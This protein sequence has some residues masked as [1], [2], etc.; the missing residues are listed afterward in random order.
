MGIL[1]VKSHNPQYLVGMPLIFV[2]EIAM[3]LMALPW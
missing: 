3:F 1:K 2:V